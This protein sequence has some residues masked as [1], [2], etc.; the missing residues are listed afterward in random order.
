MK[1]IAITWNRLVDGSGRTCPRCQATG[2]N[3]RKAVARLSPIL[4]TRGLKPVLE[5]RTLDEDRFCCAPEESNRVWIQGVPLEQ[6]VGAEVG[7]SPCCDVCGE[8]P[9]R[10]LELNGVAHEA[11]PERLVVQAVLAAAADITAE[12]GAAPVDCCHP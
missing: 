11:I 4:A 10:T 2:E 7:A 9:C 12:Q 6:W 5:T 3:I 8:Q 1:L